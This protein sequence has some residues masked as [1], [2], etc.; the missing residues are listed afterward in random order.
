MTQQLST[1]ADQRPNLT[2]G[3]FHLCTGANE[4]GLLH[5]VAWRQPSKLDQDRDCRLEIWRWTDPRTVERREVSDT[6]ADC[7]IISVALKA[8]RLTLAADSKLLFEGLMPA[9]TLYVSSPS[10]KVIAQF[11]TPCDFLHLYVGNGMLRDEGLLG[12]EVEFIE[13]RPYRDRLVELL[14]QSLVDADNPCHRAYADSAGMTIVMRAMG[15]R[16]PEKCVTSL[17]KWRL[18][19]L[20]QFIEHNVS[21]SIS[22]R[23]MADAVG[24]SRMHFA[25]QFRIAT[26][27][28]PHEYL[29]LQRVE[30]AK[31]MMLETETPL[32]E[33]ALSVGFQAQAH[34]ST[35]F[36]RFTGRSP[37]RWRREYQ[38]GCMPLE[39]FA[40]ASPGHMTSN[41]ERRL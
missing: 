15:H 19:K 18:N 23:D 17:P 16:L 26:G 32:V 13:R 2:N 3:F 38:L 24:L 21:R 20:K 34:F 30:Q 29:L 41:S 5:E 36:K 40:R 27:L 6:P 11:H 37:A 4:D 25:A 22:L 12:K 9:G 28:R 33:V 39:D 14:S 7:H 1:T 31:C 35:V 10:E 8:A